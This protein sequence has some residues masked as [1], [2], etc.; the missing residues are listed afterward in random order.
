MAE[1]QKEKAKQAEQE[2]RLQTIQWLM[3][4]KYRGQRYR[5]GQEVQVSAKEA[6]SIVAAKVA[7]P[8]D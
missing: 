3:N 8:V 2:E 1:K 7:Q 6:E 4:V 5:K